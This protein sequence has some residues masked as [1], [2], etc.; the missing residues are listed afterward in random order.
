LYAAFDGMANKPVT[1]EKKKI[2]QG[3]GTGLVFTAISGRI[4]SAAGPVVAGIA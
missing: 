3:D 1:D 4:A 2:A